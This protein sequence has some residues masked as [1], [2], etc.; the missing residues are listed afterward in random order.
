MNMCASGCST[1]AVTWVA[2]QLHLVPDMLRMQELGF[3]RTLVECLALGTGVSIGSGADMGSGVAGSASGC[4]TSGTVG[5]E[6]L[7]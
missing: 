7:L 1:L 5:A 3:V 6:N 4:C 2:T